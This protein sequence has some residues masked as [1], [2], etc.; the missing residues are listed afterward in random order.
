MT[1][2][3]SGGRSHHRARPA[4]WSRHRPDRRAPRGSRSGVSVCSSNSGCPAADG[5]ARLG[6]A[7]DAGR[8]LHVVLAPGAA[9]A[10]PPGG[11]TDGQRVEPR[12]HAG[13]PAPRRSPGTAAS[14][15]GRPDRRP[16]LRPS[17]AS[18]PSPGRR[19]APRA[20]ST[21]RPASATI[22]LASA[23]VSST[24]SAG[25]PPASTSTDSATSTALP[26]ATPERGGHVGQQCRGPDPCARTE[27]DHRPGQL[28]G[29]VGSLH[30]RAASR[31]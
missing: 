2:S 21:S 26:T 12:H 18:C 11:D 28:G 27:F 22:S 14:A 13:G 5:V 20:G 4:R 3:T 30:E 16:A 17:P 10:E 19:P 29:V 24:T 9:G 15:A 23:S 8:L 1:S 25:P 31:P 7:E 6:Q